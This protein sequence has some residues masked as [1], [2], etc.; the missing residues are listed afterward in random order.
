MHRRVVVFVGAPLADAVKVLEGEAGRVDQVVTGRAGGVFAVLLEQLAGGGVGIG[1]GNG[2]LERGVGT[3]DHMAQHR[4]AN[5]HA[6]VN[7]RRGI[8][9]GSRRQKS[10]LREDSGVLSRVARHPRPARLGGF[11]AIKVGQLGVGDGPVG[12]EQRVEAGPFFLPDSPHKAQQLFAE[13]RRAVVGPV[14]VHGEV[15]LGVVEVFEVHPLF[16]EELDNLHRAGV[17]EHPPRL[18]LEALGGG[19]RAF[20]RRLEE[21]SIGH[22]APQKVRQPR[23]QLVVVEG[24]HLAR[25]GCEHGVF[26]PVQEARRLKHHFEHHAQGRPLSPLG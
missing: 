21:R 7:G 26:D 10:A 1:L 25:R 14:G 12:G 19:Q 5:E 6:T 17:V 15:F 22:G 13:R 4:A 2:D 24:Y 8:G 9:P 20:G 16:K 18:E 3:V 23:G 11:V